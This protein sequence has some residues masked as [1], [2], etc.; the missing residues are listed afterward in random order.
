[1]QHALGWQH[2]G[3]LTAVTSSLL[4]LLLLLLLLVRPGLSRA[5]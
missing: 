3:A 4:L 5:A 1:L 2:I